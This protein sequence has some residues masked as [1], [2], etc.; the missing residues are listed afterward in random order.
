M[1]VIEKLKSPGTAAT[2][3]EKKKKHASAGTKGR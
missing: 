3:K 2:L 1:Q